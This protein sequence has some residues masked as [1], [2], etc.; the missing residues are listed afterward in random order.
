MPAS[1]FCFT[2]NGKHFGGQPPKTTPPSSAPSSS[3]FWSLVRVVIVTDATKQSCQ[4]NNAHT[5]R[6]MFTMWRRAPPLSPP[7]GRPARPLRWPPPE[8]MHLTTSKG[9]NCMFNHKLAFFCAHAEVS[10]ICQSSGFDLVP[11]RTPPLHGP[12]PALSRRRPMHTC[13]A[14][15]GPMLAGVGHECVAKACWA[16]VLMQVQ[17]VHDLQH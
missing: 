4:D 10:C 11:L 5:Q 2:C 14:G 9:D 15:A 16:H 17:S 1:M 8:Y 7:G 6:L 13:H 12:A 3:S